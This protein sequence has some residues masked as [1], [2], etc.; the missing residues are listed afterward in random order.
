VT[1]TGFGSGTWPGTVPVAGDWNGDG[2]DGIGFYSAGTWT[3]RNVATTPSSTLSPFTFNPGTKPYP[4]VGDWNADGTDTVGIRDTAGSTWYLRST[5][6]GGPLTG[7]DVV[8]SFGAAND[9]P[10]VWANGT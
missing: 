3:L 6:T 9:L 5:N 4:V 2:T 8:I 10:V 1:V 7:A